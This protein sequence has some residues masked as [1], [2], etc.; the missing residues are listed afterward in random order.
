M[1]RQSFD[2]ILRYS[3]RQ[4][5]RDIII[6]YEPICIH[7]DYVYN[8]SLT[9]ARSTVDLKGMVIHPL[10]RELYPQDYGTLG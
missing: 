4:A 3:G 9:H 6:E 10:L 8:K 1:L 5:K 7:V 2:L